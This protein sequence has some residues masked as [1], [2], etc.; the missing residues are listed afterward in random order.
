MCGIAG[1]LH[2][3]T[4]P[5]IAALKRMLA[6]VHHRGPDHT[7]LRIDGAAGL[8]HARL[9]VIDLSAAGNQP[10]HDAGL[11][12]TLVFNGVI[13][14]YK[15]LR[16]GLIGQGYRFFSCSDSEVILKSYHRWGE[17][18]VAR[19]DG[20][21]AFAIWDCKRKRLFLGRD[22][23]GIKPLYYAH[24]A[25]WFRFASNPQALL[26][27]GRVDTE[28]DPA[29]LH[30]HLSL[31]A[32]IPAPRTLLK[33]ICKLEPAH[34]LTVMNNGTTS[35][36]RY[37]RLTAAEVE[38]DDEQ[39]WLDM[40]ETKLTEAVKKRFEVADVPVGV[41]L[42]GGIDS[43]LLVTLLREA[44][45]SEINTYTIGFEN[46]AG[47]CGQEFEYAQMVAEQCATVH[48]ELHVPD[49]ELFEALP[50]VVAQM[51]E[52]M[53]SQDCAAFYLLA[54]H[55]SR[56]IKVVQTGQGADEV[57]A[58]YFWYPKM[59]R[60][61]GTDVERFTRHYFDRDHD[62]F[63]ASVA[64]RYQVGDA[65]TPLIAGLL[66]AGRERLGRQDDFVN[67]VLAADVTTLIV[68]DPVKRV[69]NM[70]MAWGLEA[71]VP[72]L[73]RELVEFAVAVP[74]H[75]KTRSGGKYLLKK[76][77]ADRLPRRVIER[78]KAYFPVPALRYL[79]NDFYR[80]AQEMLNSQACIRRSLFN[81]DYVAELLAKPDDYV[82]A[83]EGSQLWH[84]TVLE[85]WLQEHV[86]APRNA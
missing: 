7:A 75:L 36:R 60:E 33:G 70:T 17:N 16:N 40:L 68:D 81:R 4:T 15:S 25:D 41:L 67:V 38:A 12:L 23:F 37:W 27:A 49:Q 64:P 29:A 54:R 2:F 80:L 19:L 5:D 71:R 20:V 74:S 46:K 18:C 69:D 6:A 48:H 86:D 55:V 59:A 10:M 72:F 39:I 84:A 3:R 8:A 1:E 77:A 73:D 11:G 78:P 44:G 24:T 43:S 58:G 50:R 65:T 85:M 34:T 63:L 53:V 45:V 76:L 9:A 83:I 13:Y 28:I 82:T 21:F 30:H 32:V 66:E 51:A 57:F 22:R 31:H 62:E 52:P 14:N 79:R 35:C 42:S 56:D 61:S 47:A 26:A